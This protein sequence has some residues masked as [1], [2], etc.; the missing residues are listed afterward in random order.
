MKEIDFRMKYGLYYYKNTK[1]LG[2][3]IWAYAESLFYPHIDYLIDNT[4]IYSFKSTNNEKVATVISAFVEPINHEWAFMP[5]DNIIPLF[6]GSYFRSTM[7]EYIENEMVQKYLRKYAPIGVRSISNMKRFNEM[8]IE[9][10]FSGC[11]T[12]TLPKLDKRAQSKKYICCVDVPGYV[13]DFIRN[14]VGE[15]IEIK[16][17][18]HEIW[19]WSIEEQR[20]YEKKTISERFNVVRQY[21]EI[22]ANALCVVTSKLH[23]ALPCLTQETPVLLTL[24]QDGHG[25]TDMNER[26]G[27]FFE[28]FNMCSYED[29]NNDSV[30]YNFES[31]AP[32]SDK[33]RSLKVDIEDRINM[34]ISKCENGEE[35]YKESVLNNYERLEGLIEILENKIIQLKNVVDE[36]NRRL[37]QMTNEFQK[38]G[39]QSNIGFTEET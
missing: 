21:L 34:F 14:S 37:F 15:E 18:S 31:P 28:L 26:M 13:E 33:W 39:G 8:G 11:V 7:W 6:V 32:N 29:F 22:Y 23:C 5:P 2:D 3:D 27:D 19:T 38:S 16:R 24:P 12:L 35:I 17:M 36:K 10:Y 30:E 1:V 20:I 25:I 9:A 4:T